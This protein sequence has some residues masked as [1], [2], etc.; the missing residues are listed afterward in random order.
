M[1]TVKGIDFIVQIMGTTLGGQQGAT[2]NRSRETIETTHKGSG[3][4]KEI[5]PG[6]LEWSIEAD[7]LIIVD[8][9]AF[10]ILE[11][12]FVSNSAV[13]IEFRT[14]H[15]HRYIGTAHITDFPIEA[16]FEDMATYS[17]T[18]EGTGPLSASLEG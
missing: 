8:D 15:G 4:W 5:L 7:G 18:F 14:E 3:D 6:K 16:G 13:R 1:Q 9:S 12:S 10:K 11:E 17:L 2:L